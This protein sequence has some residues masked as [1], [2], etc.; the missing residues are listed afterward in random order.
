LIFW[1]IGLVLTIAG[2]IINI[3]ALRSLTD[4]INSN[5]EIGLA[6]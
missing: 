3:E 4:F 6:G 5:F 1:I 2:I